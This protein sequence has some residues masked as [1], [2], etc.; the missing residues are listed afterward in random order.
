MVSGISSFALRHRAYVLL[1]WGLILASGLYSGSH[2]SDRLT[3]TVKIPGSESDQANQILAKEFDENFEGMF[4]VIYKFK[5]STVAEVDAMKSQ[6]AQAAEV[7][8]C[9]LGNL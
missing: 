2:L 8:L 9:S 3:T 4:T 6:I 1:F 7:I 5:N